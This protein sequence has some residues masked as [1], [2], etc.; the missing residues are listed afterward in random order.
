MYKDPTPHWADINAPGDLGVLDE[1]ELRRAV[2]KRWLELENIY[3]ATW[4]Q[5]H[6]DIAAYIQPDRGQFDQLQAGNRGQRNDGCILNGCATDAMQKLGAAMD[7][8]I[9]SEAREWFLVS[10]EN[11]LD[12]EDDTNREYCHD[13]QTVLFSI[14]AKGNFYGSNRNLL[15]D[16]VGPG[17]GLMYA[18]EDDETVVRFE[19]APYGTYRLGLDGRRRVNMVAHRYVRTASQMAQE[20]GFDKISPG[21]QMAL[22]N[23][24]PQVAYQVLHV[25]EQRDL[26]RYAGDDPRARGA[27]KKP[28][29]SYWLEV[30]AGW[31]G[32]ATVMGTGEVNDYTGPQ[33]M[34]RVSGF[35]DEPFIAP[36]W[37]AIGDDAYGKESP[38]R[39]AIGDVKQLQAF[40]HQ[41]AKAIALIVQ[42]PMSAPDKMVN[43][44]LKPGAMNRIPGDANGAKFEPSVIIQPGTME[45]IRQERQILEQ[46]INRWFYGDVLFLISQDQNA[47]PKTAEE[48]RGKKEERL[49]QLVAVFSRYADEALKKVIARTF[50]LAQKRGMLPK[51]PPGLLKAGKL[52]LEF[53]NP[54]VAAQRTV[55][56]SGMQQLVSLGTALGQAKA[57]G[58][59]KLD[60]D[61][62]MNTAA[63]ML[64]VKPKLLKSNAVLAQQRQAQAQQQQAQQQGQA[65]TQAAPAIK[66]L[67]NSDP[68]KLRDLL[69]TFGPNAVA[70]GAGGGP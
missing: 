51:P 43:A 42:P 69:S 28:W 14:F 15:L 30:G 29:A 25:I 1:R 35:D 10:P 37:N 31:W 58:A 13:V 46:R 36:R 2:M 21:A 38:G 27:S 18:W 63:A 61:E 4:A 24:L 23:G 56:F 66:D 34:L 49:L 54:L 40:E 41:A 68:E 6:R 7:S 22:K 57:A 52:K 47:Q 8:G 55:G 3:N 62:I 39:N 20:F 17:T 26:R 67:S 5:P 9:T 44:S 65:M 33:G 60:T 59:D 45:A 19:H 12:A 32:A 16:L 50:Y 11:P 70:Q 53:Q 64:G 48:I